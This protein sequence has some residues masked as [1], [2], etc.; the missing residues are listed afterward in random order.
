MR[1]ACGGGEGGE[2]VMEIGNGA[3]ALPHGDARR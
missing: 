1:C 2:T 3:A